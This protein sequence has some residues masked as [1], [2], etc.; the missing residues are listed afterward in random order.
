[1]TTVKQQ[2]AAENSRDSLGP[3]FAYRPQLD[4]LRAV[5]V[6]AVIA[7]HLG[8]LPGGYLGVDL[9]F[10]L[11]GYLITSIL[12][13][14]Q[15]NSG[16]TDV[17]R[18]WRRRIRRLLPA[19]LLVVT[20]SVLASRALLAPA[21]QRST[22]KEALATLAYVA[23]WLQIAT[24]HDY[25]AQ[26]A[27]RTPLTHTWS[28]SIEEQFYLV[29]PLAFVGVAAL[30]ARR[31][32]VLNRDRS[33]Q[34]VAVL[35]GVGGVAS[36][37]WASILG[38]GLV[39]GAADPNSRAY[40]GTDTRVG[41]MLIGACLGAFLM[42][43]RSSIRGHISAAP[44]WVIDVA[45]LTV[46]IPLL[47]S[48]VRMDGYSRHLWRGGMAAAT[49]LGVAAI[50]LIGSRNDSL[51]S[52]ALT[53]RPI[54]YLG[55]I[56]YG[57][58]LWHWPIIVLLTP[59]RLG[60]GGWTL[61]LIRVAATLVVS[62]V[63]YRFVELPVRSGTTP[64]LRWVPASAAACL[65][66]MWLVWPSSPTDESPAEV[67]P[68]LA[69]AA[70]EVG[71]IRM[72]VLGD[73][74]G[75]D[76]V[77]ALDNYKRELAV[78]MA[79]M[80]DPNCAPADFGPEVRYPDGRVAAVPEQCG[81][82]LEFLKEKLATWDPD[83]VLFMYSGAATAARKV[84]GRWSASCESA[85]DRH[86]TAGMAERLDEVAEAGVLAL[87]V[88]SPYARGDWTPAGNDARVDCQNRASEAGMA[89]V[90]AGNAERPNRPVPQL[91]DL[92]GW[93]CPRR[94][95]RTETPNGASFRP[96]GVHFGPESV[97][98]ASLWIYRQVLRFDPPSVSHTR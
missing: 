39:G 69:Q 44:R 79:P 51:A 43:P 48:W 22:L 59:T 65:V 77:F 61:D 95:C 80:A 56:S 78:E 52:R 15:M 55:Q 68:D 17:R 42:M 45:T 1:M 14:E 63:S 9:F 36:M 7:F 50:V 12:L 85:Y 67:S 28:L 84:D 24:E 35:A 62:A 98:D 37:A 34:F 27:P 26:F 18:F 29:W 21:V 92:K 49:L 20:A 8:R 31:A 25:W 5:A 75:F 87:V 94:E 47:A 86:W 74:T 32:A 10:V 53:R 73:S 19:S 71:Q 16:R 23:N 60:F 90:A 91:I 82:Q 93:V 97:D 11:S 33:A 96:D 13:A 46:S 64:L 57:V 40:F 88:N 38:T 54:V 41:A 3:R 2:G 83:V 6:V 89:Q 58:Y 76:F 66:L 72:V 4:G 70:A 81:R 30:A